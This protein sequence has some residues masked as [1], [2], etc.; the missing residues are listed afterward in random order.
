MACI[1]WLWTNCAS[2]VF[3]SVASVSTAMTSSG[4]PRV[5]ATWT[6]VSSG[7]R[8]S[9]RNSGRPSPRPAAASASH[10]G[11]GR[12]SPSRSCPRRAPSMSSSLRSNRASRF[13]VRMRPSGVTRRSAI[14]RPSRIGSGPLP[15]A[16]AGSTATSL[17]PGP[18]SKHRSSTR[19]GP[20]GV[21]RKRTVPAQASSLTPSSP[22]S[23]T[24]RPNRLRAA[25]FM[26]RTAPRRPMVSTGTPTSLPPISETGDIRQSVADVSIRRPVM[27]RAL[28]PTRKSSVAYPPASICA[29]RRCRMAVGWAIRGRRRVTSDAPTFA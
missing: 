18:A 19:C 3:S 4:A 22:S 27:C 24:R 12:P 25:S 26:A 20:S 23:R 1:F 6:I 13:A 16:G 21:S 8:L 15:Y 29:A 7:A 10:S 14:G 11:I 28:L 2:S 5:S 17:R 9:R